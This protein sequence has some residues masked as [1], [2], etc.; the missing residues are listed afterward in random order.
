MTEVLY[1]LVLKYIAYAVVMYMAVRMLKIGHPDP[2]GFSILW[3]GVKVLLGIPFGAAIFFVYVL[4][5][6]LGDPV[7]YL[8][9]FGGIR[10][11]EWYVMYRLISHR[12]Q[13]RNPGAVS[14]WVT[15]GTFVSLA[16]DLV[17]RIWGLEVP[18]F[19]C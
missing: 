11:I 1:F 15:L 18:K 14:A 9:A 7:A 4:L 6:G 2:V 16:S 5:S 19:V 13:V 17:W 10:V 8:V 3:S 12:H